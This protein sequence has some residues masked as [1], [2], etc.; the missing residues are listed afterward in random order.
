MLFNN[1]PL[2]I[3]KIPYNHV[4]KMESPEYLASN[5]PVS[6][7]ELEEKLEQYEPYLRRLKLKTKISVTKKLLMLSLA[8]RISK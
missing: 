5:F 1:K 6:R 2:E 4:N 7:E 8:V 3:N